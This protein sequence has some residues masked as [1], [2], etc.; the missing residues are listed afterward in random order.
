MEIT[1]VNAGNSAVTVDWDACSLTLPSARTERII[2]TSVR[3]LN[4]AMPQA[5]TTIPSNGYISESIWPSTYT[6][7][8]K[9]FFW[10]LLGDPAWVREQISLP[11]SVGTLGLFLTWSD[12]AGKHDGMWIWTIQEDP[13]KGIHLS[14]FW[15][16]FIAGWLIVGAIGILLFPDL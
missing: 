2:H 8:C 16:W 10:G 4:S 3:Y 5:S 7:W 1:I 12:S 13:R 9:L 11:A 6:T 14:P 15:Q